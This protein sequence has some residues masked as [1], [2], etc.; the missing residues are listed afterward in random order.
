MT[1]LP[2]PP[3]D[4]PTLEDND[5]VSAQGMPVIALPGSRMNEDH[6]PIL[7]NSHIFF[8]KGTTFL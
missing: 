1:T 2:P 4:A 8:I 3:A 5:I 7:F 6:K